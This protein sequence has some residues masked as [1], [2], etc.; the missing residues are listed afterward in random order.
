MAGSSYSKAMSRE[1]LC[2]HTCHTESTMG[3]Q[4]D[5]YL[6]TQRGPLNAGGLVTY[7]NMSETGHKLACVLPRHSAPREE[8]KSATL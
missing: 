6:N 2:N 1:A 7:T 8:T 3:V 4:Y 5:P